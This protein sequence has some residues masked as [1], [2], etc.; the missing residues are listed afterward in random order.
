MNPK[1]G[2]LE[3]NILSTDILKSQRPGYN[4]MNYA[5]SSNDTNYSIQKLIDDLNTL[6][7]KTL[8][9]FLKDQNIKFRSSLR[10]SQLIDFIIANVDNEFIEAFIDSEKSSGILSKS[11]AKTTRTKTND[12]DTS[13]TNEPLSFPPKIQFP[14]P[15]KTQLPFSP[16]IQHDIEL[17]EELELALK[18]SQFEEDQRRKLINAVDAIKNAE[19]LVHDAEQLLDDNDSDSDIEALRKSEEIKAL[20]LA[21]LAIESSKISALSLINAQN[22]DEEISLT[23]QLPHSKYPIDIPEAELYNISVRIPTQ[24]QLLSYVYSMHEPLKTLVDHIKHD[25]SYNNGIRL[26]IS[27]INKKI[28]CPPS[29]SLADCGITDRSIINVFT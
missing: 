27:G 12:I 6:T 23:V 21:R 24:R 17:D 13:N 16:Q 1:P 10:K 28:T 26:S 20:E 14:S 22:N 8:Q 15:S 2:S 7:L 29:A 5:A 9:Q 19:E 3:D 4:P 25:M 11:K 18:I